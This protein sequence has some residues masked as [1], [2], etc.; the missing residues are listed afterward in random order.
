MVVSAQIDAMPVV[1]DPKQFDPRSGTWL[2]R[3]VFNHRI[4]FIVVCGVA[5]V[6]LGFQLTKIGRAHV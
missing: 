4:L 3:L 2:E 1:G 6:L 5:T